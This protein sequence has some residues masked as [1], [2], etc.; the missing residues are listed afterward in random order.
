MNLE[1]ESRF[2][3][4][5]Q[6]TAYSKDAQSALRVVIR[7]VGRN[8]AYSVHLYRIPHR[9]ASVKNYFLGLDTTRGRVIH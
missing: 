2:Q 1:E 3:M 6:M 8:C 9:V 5:E 4:N 7:V